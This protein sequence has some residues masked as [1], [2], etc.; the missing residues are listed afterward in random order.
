MADIK[1]LNL[2]IDENKLYK[3][4]EVADILNCSTRWVWNRINTEPYTLAGIRLA[5]GN[6]N[7]QWRITGKDLLKYLADNYYTISKD[8]TTNETE[9]NQ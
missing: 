1:D 9:T 6:D 4:G 7:G 8:K 3:I 5:N 2:N